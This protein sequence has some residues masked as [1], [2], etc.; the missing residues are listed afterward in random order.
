[1]SMQKRKLVNLLGQILPLLEDSSS[2]SSS[3]D[4]ERAPP[5]KLPKCRQYFELVEEMDEQKLHSHFRLGKGEVKLHGISL[6]TMC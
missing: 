6:L 2:S 5:R 1:M 3:S 4:E